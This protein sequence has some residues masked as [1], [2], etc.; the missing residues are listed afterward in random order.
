M[1]GLLL[2]DLARWPADTILA[3]IHSIYD[4]LSTSSAVVDRVLEDLDAPGRLDHNVEAVRIILLEL[5]EH[6]F[7]IRSTQRQVHIRGIKALGQ[8]DLE[9]LRRGDDDVAATVLTQHLGENET[10]GAGAEHEHRGT[11]L[12]RDL[13]E[14]VGGARGRLEEGGIDVGEVLDWEDAASWEKIDWSGELSLREDC[15]LIGA[16]RRLYQDRH[17]TRRSHRPR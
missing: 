11:H 16:G 4:Q 15:E 2:T 12:G 3:G 13:V 8:I 14:A 5:V 1:G 17:N 6:G 10:G 9:T 7:G